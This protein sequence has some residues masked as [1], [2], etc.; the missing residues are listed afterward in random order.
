MRAESVR[1]PKTSSTR[2][3]LRRWVL[4][5][6][7]VAL[8]APLLILSARPASAAQS[9]KQ[10]L[11]PD[12]GV[13][14]QQ[15]E[16]FAFGNRVS[17]S[18]FAAAAAAALQSTTTSTSTS[19]G[20]IE[21]AKGGQT[22]YGEWLDELPPG[23]RYELT[24]CTTTKYTTTT[25]IITPEYCPPLADGFDPAIWDPPP[26][27]PAVT[28]TSTTSENLGKTIQSK[29]VKP[30]PSAQAWI[31]SAAGAALDSIGDQLDAVYW[32]SSPHPDRRQVVG[33]NTW[34]AV[35]AQRPDPGATEGTF[36]NDMTITGSAG[37]DDGQ[38]IF[39]AIDIERP[40]ATFK[41][42]DKVGG[43]NVAIKCDS[44]GRLWTE[45]DA[46]LITADGPSPELCVRTWTESSV[47]GT[48][49]DR[50]KVEEVE[51]LYAWALNQTQTNAMFVIGELGIPDEDFTGEIGSEK[52]GGQR[53]FVIGEVQTYGVDPDAELRGDAAPLDTE[54]VG[55]RERLCDQARNVPVL[56]WFAGQVCDL[57][58]AIFNFHAAAFKA[59]WDGVQFV[60][61]VIKVIA[62]G[63]WD[64]LQGCIEAGSDFLADIGDTATAVVNFVKD[65]GGQIG[66]VIQ[67][68]EMIEQQL[69]NPETRWDFVQ[70]VLMDLFGEFLDLDLI[71]D[72]VGNGWE[73]KDDPQWAKWIG[74]VA[75]G[76]LLSAVTAGAGKALKATKVGRRI[77]RWLNGGL[78]DAVSCIVKIT[79]RGPGFL[80]GM[81][82]F[83]EIS[84]HAAQQTAESNSFPAGTLVVMADGSYQPI[85]T[86]NIGDSVLSFDHTNNWW[87]PQPVI[88]HWS[89]DDHGQM[90]TVTLANGSSLQATDGHLFWLTNE[91]S[92]VELEDVQ[93]GDQFLTPTGPTTVAAVVEAPATTTLVYELTVLDNHNFVV[94]TGSSDLLVH[95]A[96]RNRGNG[97]DGGDEGSDFTQNEDTG[98]ITYETEFGDIEGVMLHP[99]TRE[100]MVL[101]NGDFQVVLMQ[102]GS[103][104][105]IDADGNIVPGG[106]LNQDGSVVVTNP[107]GTQTLIDKEGDTTSAPGF[108]CN[109]F[110]TGTQVRL[111]SGDYRAIEDIEIG[112][113]VLSYDTDAE[114]WVGALVINHWSAIDDGVMTTATL[115][116]GAQI[117]AT[118]HHRFWAASL[119]AWIPLDQADGV[120]FLSP[121]STPAVAQIH[122]AEPT[123]TLVWE[124]TVQGTHNFTVQAGAHDLL[125]H[126]CEIEINQDGSYYAVGEDATGNFFERTRDVNGN[127]T[128][129]TQLPNDVTVVRSESKNGKVTETTTGR[130]GSTTTRRSGDPE[131][132]DST[133]YNDPNTGE[134]RWEYS[135]G[136]VF[137]DANGNRMFRDNSGNVT[138]PVAVNGSGVPRVHAGTGQPWVLDTAT[139]VGD[140]SSRSPALEVSQVDANGNPTQYV[141]PTSGLIYDNNDGNF[142]DRVD[143]L[144]NHAA[145]IPNRGQ[146][147]GVFNQG[148]DPATVVD[149]AYGNRTNGTQTTK[150]DGT[151][152]YEVPMGSPV[153]YAGGNGNGGTLSTVRIEVKNGVVQTAYPVAP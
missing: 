60:A 104:T 114:T 106:R 18:S 24:L 96:C 71:A 142:H 110:P 151:I 10:L 9:I 44:G 2:H 100:P 40:V 68:V 22:L 78:P 147:H 140:Q 82:D 118:D 72:R 134:R 73:L 38:E 35:S 59:V 51:L 89:A 12:F 122:N 145:D 99:E 19:C 6:L 117:S 119:N 8:I 20:E 70:N 87:E 69:A 31:A 116:D 27:T 129:T 149:Q 150:A 1:Q 65:P 121:T 67:T 11:P 26:C 32:S 53:N 103:V 29:V 102:D 86:V 52:A 5:G 139:Q 57:I 23:M 55:P 98:V 77:Q 153:G 46:D 107:D 3:V 88:D 152:V 105:L 17:T 124:M 48:G 41:F 141:S 30:H 130:D 28:S 133:E 7:V 90:A 62:S 39:I 42:D 109:S 81:Q 84:N 74:K 97:G 146:P 112:D 34:F 16:G 54:W 143:H 93:P 108:T 131:R 137:I 120:S 76:V 144:N 64:L 95:N 83:V 13:A 136:E 115:E 33:L 92:W 80:A 75:C 94:S 91:Q 45:A 85:E 49:V 37:G 47:D 56:G 50:V 148:S 63:A 43:D 79:A 125:V 113:E 14:V 25:E 61:T 36:L 127:V 111:A 126:N 128:T 138:G 15:N 4:Q 101:N 66:E 123:Q 132:F 135:T 58:S 21:W